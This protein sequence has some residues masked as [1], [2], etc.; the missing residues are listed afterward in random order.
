MTINVRFIAFLFLH[1]WTLPDRLLLVHGQQSPNSI[2]GF[3]ICSQHRFYISTDNKYS[4][5][6]QSQA[7]VHNRT[8]KRLTTQEPMCGRAFHRCVLT[9]WDLAK[10]PLHISYLAPPLLLCI[11]L[12]S[13]SLD[14]FNR[15]RESVCVCAGTQVTWHTCGGQKTT[16]GTGSF[17][18]PCLRQGLFVD[19]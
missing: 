8:A 6:S 12:E 15:E 13:L 19:L 1:V 16:T 2:C 18:W 9:Y 4:R 10:N 5:T 17:L 7:N 14:L 3:V 11:I